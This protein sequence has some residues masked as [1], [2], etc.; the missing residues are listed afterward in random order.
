M[1]FDN[2][3]LMNILV[4]TLLFIVLSPGL[5]LTLPP[6]SKGKI[7]MSHE[8]SVTAILVHAVV[9]ALLFFLVR[10]YFSKYY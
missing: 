9:F 6:V 1:Q 3:T 7:F 2:K 10:H 4:P 8:T 5:L